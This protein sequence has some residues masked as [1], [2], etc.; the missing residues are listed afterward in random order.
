MK[1][2]VFLL[3]FFMISASI[4]QA[5]GRDLRRAGRQLNRGNLA[6]AKEYIEAAMEYEEVFEEAE[7]WV[8]KAQL[9]MEIAL[10]EEPEYR[11]LVDN[12]VDKADEALTKAIELDKD[13]EFMLEIQQGKLLMSELVFN[14]GVEAYGRE[15]W[16]AASDYFL[17][18]YEINLT[19]ETVDTTTLYN[20]ALSAELGHDFERAIDMYK[21]LKDME[22]DQPYVYSS[23]ANVSMHIGDTL[24]GTE[25]IQEGRERYPENLDLIFTEANIH[26]FTGNI[27]EASRVLNLAIERDPENPGLYFAF[28]ANYDRMAQDTLYS[29]E[30]REF[31]F[32]EAV[33]A[34][35]KAIELDPDYFD[36]VYNLG[37]LYF[38]KGLSLFEEAE[39]RLRETQDF[40]QYEEDEKEVR[41]AWL[42][43]QPYLERA[44]DMIDEDDPNYRTVVISLVELYLRTNQPEKFEEIQDIYEKHFGTMEEE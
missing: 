23:L 39:D 44:K 9:Y 30:D 29:K 42:E 6:D 1:R 11:G 4:A 15:D 25:F 35:E 37:A 12:P 19:F 26:I 28:G 36:A 21:Q 38:N 17:R 7:I 14:E 22:Y 34:Y 40:A 20:A 41:K 31:A 32:E 3:I 16:A 10:T 5:Q 27:E 33:K 24:Q 2:I 13:D 43:A 8:L 18:A